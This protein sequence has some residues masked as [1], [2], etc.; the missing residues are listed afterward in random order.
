[1]VNLFDQLPEA[2]ST[3]HKVVVFSQFIAMIETME[4]KLSEENI[5]FVSLTGDKKM[6]KS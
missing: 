6:P 5:G 1:M 4:Q 2:L 3:G